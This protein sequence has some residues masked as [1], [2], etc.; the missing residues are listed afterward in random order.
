MSSPSSTSAGMSSWGLEL[1]PP[2]T[3]QA[4]IRMNELL[5]RHILEPGGLHASGAGAKGAGA[6]RAGRGEGAELRTSGAAATQPFAVHSTR[7]LSEPFPSGAAAACLSYEQ[8]TALRGRHAV[9]KAGV[10]EIKREYNVRL[11]LLR[12]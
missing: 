10:L 9:C 7:R 3:A 2:P 11:A 1:L 5:P 8:R 12:G 6:A 4:A